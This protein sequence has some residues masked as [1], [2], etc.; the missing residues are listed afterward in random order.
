MDPENWTKS[1]AALV[2]RMVL[3]TDSGCSK[4]S[5]CMKLEKL[6][7]M[8][9]WISSMMVVISRLSGDSR[10]TLRLILQQRHHACLKISGLTKKFKGVL[11]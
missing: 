3:T 5:L 6:P 9:C 11:A 7:F 1:V 10:S 2:P 4:I 8:I